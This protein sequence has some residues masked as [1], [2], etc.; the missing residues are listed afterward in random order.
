[1]RNKKRTIP[2]EVWVELYC[3]LAEWHIKTMDLNFL[4]PTNKEAIS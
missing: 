3:E 2:P 1:M 4:V